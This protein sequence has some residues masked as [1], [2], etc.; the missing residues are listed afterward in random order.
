[1]EQRGSRF[2]RVD[3]TNSRPES[4]GHAVIHILPATPDTVI[5]R[6]SHPNGEETPNKDRVAIAHGGGD[7][8]SVKAERWLLGAT[9]PMQEKG[10]V[11]AF[12]AFR[13]SAR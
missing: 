9:L 4:S 3:E 7:R 6:N 13:L 12:A 11:R 10:L 8:D 2:N 1:M 5:H